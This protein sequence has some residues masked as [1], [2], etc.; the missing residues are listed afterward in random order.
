[1]LPGCPDGQSFLNELG[2]EVL[3]LGTAESGFRFQLTKSLVWKVYGS[4]H[5]T[6]FAQKRI[7]VKASISATKVVARSAATETTNTDVND[8]SVTPDVSVDEDSPTDSK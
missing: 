5:K 8:D 3:K 7:R 2:D 4:S 6:I 1:M